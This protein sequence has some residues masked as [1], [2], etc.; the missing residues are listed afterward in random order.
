LHALLVA[1]LAMPANSA[2]RANHAKS[3][4]HTEHYPVEEV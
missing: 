1:D 2:A 4:K 3:A